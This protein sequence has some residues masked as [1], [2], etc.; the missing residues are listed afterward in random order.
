MTKEVCQ[1]RKAT[2][3]NKRKEIVVAMIKTHGQTN[4][5]A[6][7]SDLVPYL[8]FISE[9]TLRDCSRSDWDR[10]RK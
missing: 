1:Q 6:A 8:P 10:N 9:M 2:P 4:M 7:V 5:E 3:T